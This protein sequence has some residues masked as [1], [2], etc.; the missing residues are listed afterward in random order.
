MQFRPPL[1]LRLSLLMTSGSPSCFRTSRTHCM[2]VVPTWV[3]CTRLVWCLEASETMKCRFFNK[4]LMALC[5]DWA[6]S[7]VHPRLSLP[8]R[9]RATAMVLSSLWRRGRSAKRCW[10]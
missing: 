3:L 7:W 10:Q 9:R 4:D 1:S 5:T 6:S 8:L 2:L